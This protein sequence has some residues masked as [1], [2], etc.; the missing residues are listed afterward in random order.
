MPKMMIKKTCRILHCLKFMYC[1]SV[2]RKDAERV[3]K[4]NDEQCLFL[5]KEK[6]VYMGWE[7]LFKRLTFDV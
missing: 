1:V 5:N 3:R 2:C 6:S 4:Q 7:H